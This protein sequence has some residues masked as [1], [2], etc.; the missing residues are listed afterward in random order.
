MSV[1]FEADSPLVDLTPW[2]RLARAAFR[3][4]HL[5]PLETA[6]ALRSVFYR[7]AAQR[8]PCWHGD[9]NANAD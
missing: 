4:H 1:S 5:L 8:H 3:Y 2:E 6:S 9:G 7:V